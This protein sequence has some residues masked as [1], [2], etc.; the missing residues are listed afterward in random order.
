MKSA[1]EK[2]VEWLSE[3]HPE[4]MPTPE[5]LERLKMCELLDQQMAYNAGFAMAK[6]I[7]NETDNS[8]VNS[9]QVR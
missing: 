5:V 3:T 2:F 7:Y 8:P 6:K 9:K 4:V 1:I